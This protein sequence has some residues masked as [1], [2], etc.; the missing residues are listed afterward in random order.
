MN[1]VL[2]DPASP[3]Y[4]PSQRSF[5]GLLLYPQMRR[6]GQ[7]CG[8]INPTTGLP[9]FSNT[10]CPN[11]NWNPEWRESVRHVI[12]KLIRDYNVDPN[13]IYV[14]GLSG[15]GEAT[16]QFIRDYPGLCSSCAPHVCGR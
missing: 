3:T 2:N 13:R 11:N 4:N 14:H 7:F 9:D 6:T 5:P 15:G 1:A 12:D 8:A 10:A 16:L